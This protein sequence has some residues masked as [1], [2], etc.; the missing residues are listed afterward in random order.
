MGVL[1]GWSTPSIIWLCGSIVIIAGWNVSLTV[2]DAMGKKLPFG[3]AVDKEADPQLF[4]ERLVG[5][6][7]GFTW[8][9]LLGLFLIFGT[10]GALF[11]VVPRWVVSKLRRTTAI[12]EVPVDL[13]PYRSAPHSCMTCGQTIPEKAAT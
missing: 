10:A 11:Y 1:S 4:G 5:T 2:M 13:G 7:V 6:L 9:A 8:P 3:I 12:P